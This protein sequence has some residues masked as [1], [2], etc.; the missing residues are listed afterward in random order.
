MVVGFDFN[1]DFKKYPVENRIG[2][3]SVHLQLSLAGL[4]GNH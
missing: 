1:L 4:I 2:L 3:C